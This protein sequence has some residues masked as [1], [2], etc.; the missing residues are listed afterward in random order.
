MRITTGERISGYAFIA[1][2][3]ILI[4][5]FVIWPTV[6]MAITSVYEQFWSR[7]PTAAAPTFE[8]YHDVFAEQQ[9]RRSVAN[10]L[11]FTVMVVP[12]QAALALGLAAWANRPGFH[13]RLLRVAVFVPTTISLAVLSV[14]WTL[15][16]RTGAADGSGAGLINGLLTSAGLPPQPLLESP[17]QALPALALM[18]IWQGVGLQMMIFLS[19]LQQIPDQLYEAASLD[20]AGPWQRFRNVTLPGVAPTAA[21]VIM[22]TTIFALRL[23]VQPHIMTGGGPQNA[24]LSLVQ[25]VYRAAFIEGDFGLACAAAT[26]LFVGVACIAVIMRSALRWTEELT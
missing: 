16:Y 12:L 19:G 14:L 20:G 4:G 8:H 6:S 5:L 1:P 21:F 26:L 3:V 25:Y 2:A 13:A 22:V 7:V 17:Y 9:F 11:W 15:M 23:F 10:T 18:S 24:T